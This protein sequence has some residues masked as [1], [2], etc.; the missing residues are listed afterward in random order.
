MFNCLF[1]KTKIIPPHPLKII[2]YEIIE[3]IENVVDVSPKKNRPENE[4]KKKME[5]ET[6]RGVDTANDYKKQINYT[7]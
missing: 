4:T 3:I 7:V 2:L 6:K 5:E 1:T